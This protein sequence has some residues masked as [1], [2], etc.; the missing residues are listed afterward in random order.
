MP[1]RK[2]EKDWT[3][4]AALVLL[5]ILVVKELGIL[6]TLFNI[7]PE[8]SD[9]SYMTSACI[10][11]VITELHKLGNALSKQGE[12]IAKIEGLLEKHS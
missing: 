2:E 1:K 9:L 4:T 6:K 7:D 11:Y 10:V 3:L 5:A 8:A 12:R